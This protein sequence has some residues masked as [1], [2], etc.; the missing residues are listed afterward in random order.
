M[1]NRD[2]QAAERREQILNISKKL[3]LKNGYHATSMRNINKEVGLS[4]ALTYHYFPNGKLEI[5]KA[6]VESG[7]KKSMSQIQTV[8]K[9]FQD[10]MPLKDAL[11]IYGKNIHTIFA[12]DESVIPLVI[13]EHNLLDK[14]E[15]KFINDTTQKLIDTFVSYLNNL[16]IKPQLK[17]FNLRLGILQY[18]Y[19][20]TT[21]SIFGESLFNDNYDEYINELADMTIK[22]WCK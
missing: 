3:F 16:K 10:H 17:T 15:Y 13:R 20:F 9:K 2:V 6:I 4:E 7:H 18:T 8:I 5:F 11:V 14:S 19:N 22:L 21:S 12:D 1:T